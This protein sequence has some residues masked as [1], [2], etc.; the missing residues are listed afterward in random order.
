MA[1][2]NRVTLPR[3]EW[4]EDVLERWQTVSEGLSPHER[5]RLGLGLGRWLKWTKDEALDPRQ[6]TPG[7]LEACW[8]GLAVDARNSVRRALALMF[9][10]RRAALYGAT[11]APAP[12]RDPRERLAREIT[13]HLA[14]FP[15]DW[16]SETEP[17]VALDPD[18]LADGRLAAAW[19]PSSLGRTLQA[20]AAFFEA[21]R[22]TGLPVDITPVTIRTWLRRWQAACDAGERRVGGAAI[23]IERLL[24]LAR[25]VRR[26]RDWA[27]LDRAARSMKK[28]SAHHVS[29]NAARAVDAAE[30]R[31]AGERLLGAA[32]AEHRVAATFRT[33]AVAHTRA[34]TAVCA[35][36]LSEAPI[37]VGTLAG[38]TL[39]EGLL[40]ELRTAVL[41]RTT[42][43]EGRDDVR[44]LS[45]LLVRALRQYVEV[46]RPVVAPPGE[47]ALFLGK[48]GRP[49]S[50]AVLSRMFGDQVEHWF[51]L[52]ATPHAI[53]H[54][55][56]RFIVAT[57]PEEAG[58]ASVILHHRNAAVTENYTGN[59]GQ[60]R[61]S[62]RLRTT[63]GATAHE[64]G[65]RRAPE[66]HRRPPPRQRP[67]SR[68]VSP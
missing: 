47:T 48:R 5:E 18:R 56:A 45:A 40:G 30:L 55:A 16:R 3:A 23:E 31:A 39:N 1:P 37:R 27:W 20:G 42:T 34:R 64:L 21:C 9:P 51:G 59:A 7:F 17:L 49:L 2:R 65:A 10:E 26:G 54:S 58:L 13:R 63:T 52:R 22:E 57:A 36:L 4:P 43:K 35:I 53:R 29:R 66:K 8:Q 24:A 6:V 41:P 12:R 38:L 50:A 68:R 33:M 60:V 61:A 62:Q 44:G 67:S 25:G 14:R 46:H 15:D 32:L 19:A 11:R 28:L